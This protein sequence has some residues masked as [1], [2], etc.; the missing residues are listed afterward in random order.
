VFGID[1][2]RHIIIPFGVHIDFVVNDG[3]SVQSSWPVGLLWRVYC[4]FLLFE[5]ANNILGCHRGETAVE[6]P[7]EVPRNRIGSHMDVTGAIC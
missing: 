1:S 7:F 4:V 3:M 2:I 5:V 6:G